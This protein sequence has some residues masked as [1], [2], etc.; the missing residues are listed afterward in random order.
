MAWNRRKVLS[1]GVA[2]TSCC[3]LGCDF[4]SGD[5]ETTPPA[6][7]TPPSRV[8]LGGSGCYRPQYAG[9]QPG[10][11]GCGVLPNFGQPTLDRQWLEEI[12]LQAQFFSP[13]QAS[14]HV[15]DECDPS[16]ANA[17]A[18]PDGYI[19]FG[20]YLAAQL[21]Q[22]TGTSLP[23]ASVLAHEWG[24]RLQFTYG[25]MQQVEPTVRRTELE[26][27]MWSGLYMG[28]M[29]S[30][31]GPQMQSFFQTLFDMG[32]F[33]FNHPSHHGTPNQRLAAGATGLTLAVQLIQSQQRLSAAQVHSLFLTEVTRITT[34]V[35]TAG[36]EVLLK[37]MLEREHAKLQWETRAIGDAMDTEWIRGIVRGDRRLDEL[38]TMPELPEQ[39][40]I[41]LAPY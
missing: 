5:D 12:Q 7:N 10:G 17:L 29:K 25:W 22:R 28:L 20:R 24:H 14:V 41:N 33:N 15:L 26:A 18:T 39:L 4:G 8:A 37:S 34:T 1:A 16:Q 31:A 30:W 6:T 32:D 2:A 11:L 36:A 9:V 21:I 13:A 27:D 38:T 35:Q 3:I 40:R 23:I 19:L